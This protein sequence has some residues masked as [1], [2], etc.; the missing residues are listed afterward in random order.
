[1]LKKI[2]DFFDNFNFHK[3][4]TKTFLRAPVN[5]TDL[6]CTYGDYYKS[7]AYKGSNQQV[8][9]WH[10]FKLSNLRFWNIEL[11]LNF[12]TDVILQWPFGLEVKWFIKL[13]NL[14][15]FLGGVWFIIEFLRV[16]ILSKLIW[17]WNFHTSVRTF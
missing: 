15:I 12:F 13:D 3:S 9:S 5:L 10:W 6:K 1:M 17:F 8:H 11:I 7:A 16:W 2:N 14:Q 4:S